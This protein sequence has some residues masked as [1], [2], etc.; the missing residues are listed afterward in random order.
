MKIHYKGLVGGGMQAA[1]WEKDGHI[2]IELHP[3]KGKEREIVDKLVGLCLEQQQVF[4]C[5]TAVPIGSK[6]ARVAKFLIK[7]A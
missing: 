2:F 6:Y 5:S 7:A 3:K 1:I 4:L